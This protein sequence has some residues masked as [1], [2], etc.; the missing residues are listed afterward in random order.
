M[1]FAAWCEGHCCC[2]RFGGGANEE[3]APAGRYG[4]V[5]RRTAEPVVPLLPHPAA[6]LASTSGG[7]P[8][9]GSPLC[10]WEGSVCLKDWGGGR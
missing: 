3:P 7:K 6:E 1:W 4:P 5:H 9:L 10:V 2:R 8:L